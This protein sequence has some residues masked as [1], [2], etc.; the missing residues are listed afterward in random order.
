MLIFKKIMILRIVLILKLGQKEF[1]LRT[2]K[3]M[4][5]SKSVELTCSSHLSLK[6]GILLLPTRQWIL[7]TCLFRVLVVKTNFTQQYF[8][9]LT[10]CQG[11]SNKQCLQLNWTL[12][13]HLLTKI[14]SMKFKCKILRVMLIMM[15]H[16]L[17][18]RSIS[19]EKS[20]L[21]K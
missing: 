2:T 17:L 6:V 14:K 12:G 8:S 4:I 3:Q 20:K 13:S 21:R 1:S 18:N 10:L 5:K 16:Q 11:Y 9:P 7:I 19:K 15:S